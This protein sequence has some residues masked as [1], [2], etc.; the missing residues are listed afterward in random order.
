MSNCYIQCTSNVFLSLST[1]FK[2]YDAIYKLLCLLYNI[3]K[4]N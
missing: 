2:G 1:D 4:D 3:L